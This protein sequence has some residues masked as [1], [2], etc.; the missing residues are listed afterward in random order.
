M[1]PEISQTFS[2]RM[3]LIR[4]LQRARIPILAVA[5]TYFLSVSAGMIMVQTG[6]ERAIAQR[7][8][9]VSGA[10]ASSSILALRQNNR[11]QAALLDFG[12]NLYGAIAT[13]I[14]GLGVITSFPIIAYRGWIGGIVSID[15]SH[16]SRLAESKEALYYLVTLLLQLI[17][18]SLTG[19]AGVNVG[20]SLFRP[21]SYYQGEKWLGIPA[22]AIRDTFRIFLIAI[23][24]FLVASLWEFYCR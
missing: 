16:A 20:W 3:P 4:A 21:P 19:G 24:L 11:L 6:N 23:P 5:L 13:T 7:D 14:A 1:Q 9:I 12:G 2:L 22:E 15:S 17:P 10:Q 18:Y 8:R